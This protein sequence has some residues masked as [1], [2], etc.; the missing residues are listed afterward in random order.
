VTQRNV[1][2]LIGRLLTDEDFR[3]TF[4]ADPEQS[5]RD[6]LER[7]IHLTPLEIAALVSMDSA[8]WRRAADEIDPRLQKARLKWPLAE[9]QQP[10]A[11]SD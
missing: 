2:N 11:D 9:S 6:L 7:G 4:A 5:L 3:Q 10:L 1:E 8:L